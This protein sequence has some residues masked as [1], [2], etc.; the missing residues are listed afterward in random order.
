MLLD[1]A[2]SGGCRSLVLRIAVPLVHGTQEQGVLLCGLIIIAYIPARL[3]VQECHRPTL[4]P[5][6]FRI[7]LCTSVTDC[8][9]ARAKNLLK[10]NMLLQLDGKTIVGLW[11]SLHSV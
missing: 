1:L 10:T 3:E 8:E 11:F 9:V 6:S 5:L 2:F 7:R 4:A